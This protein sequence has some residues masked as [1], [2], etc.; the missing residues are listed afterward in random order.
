MLHHLG[1]SKAAAIEWTCAYL[2][3][4]REVFDGETDCKEAM[5]AVI[6]PLADPFVN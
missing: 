2:N 1:D 4:G 3:G 5:E 6:E